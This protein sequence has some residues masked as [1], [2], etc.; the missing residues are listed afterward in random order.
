MC[1]VVEFKCIRCQHCTDGFACEIGQL[2]ENLR[3]GMSASGANPCNMSCI[4]QRRAYIFRFLVGML[5]RHRRGLCSRGIVPRINLHRDLCLC[6]IEFLNAE[7]LIPPEGTRRKRCE[8]LFACGDLHDH[9]RQIGVIRINR[10]D[11]DRQRLTGIHRT[12]GSAVP[13]IPV[14]QRCTVPDGCKARRRLVLL[15]TAAFAALQRDIALGICIAHRL[16]VMTADIFCDAVI[17]R[18]IQIHAVEIQHLIIPCIPIDI[19]AAQ[20]RHTVRESALQ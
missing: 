19:I 2:R 9:I 16:P 17:R 11:P 13:I 20:N 1:I 5:Q 3:A 12:V 14:V 4:G 6:L 18:I 8:V 7:T 15:L 10:I